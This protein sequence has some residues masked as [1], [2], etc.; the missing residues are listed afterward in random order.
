MPIRKNFEQPEIL[1]FQDMLQLV[2]VGVVVVVVVL[3]LDVVET[4]EVNK[5]MEPHVVV[6]VVRRE[7]LYA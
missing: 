4:V 5:M 2:L 7:L 6:P 1:D 3:V